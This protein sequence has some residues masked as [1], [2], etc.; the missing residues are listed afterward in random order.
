[1]GNIR[2]R[3]SG[4]LTGGSFGESGKDSQTIQAV[5]YKMWSSYISYHVNSGSYYSG[6]GMGGNYVGQAYA[7][8]KEPVVLFVAFLVGLFLCWLD[9]NIFTNK[10]IKGFIIFM[11]IQSVIYIPRDNLL[12]FVTDLIEPLI[13]LIF[14]YVMYVPFH[15]LTT[16]SS[17]YELSK[18]LHS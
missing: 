14:V 11:I 4:F 9:R 10:V 15:V 17:K 12:D 3:L 8:G 7:A 2:F 18:S 6:G 16:K 13:M 5:K 1:M